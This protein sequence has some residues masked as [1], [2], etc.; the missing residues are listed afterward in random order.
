ME[1]FL[2]GLM[3]GTTLALLV[4]GLLL[5]IRGEEPPNLFCR[6]IGHDYGRAGFCE[7]CGSRPQASK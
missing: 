3:T 4:I 5:W 2:Y 1:T 7:R 6:R